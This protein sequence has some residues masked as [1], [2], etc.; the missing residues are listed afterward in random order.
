MD[1]RVKTA[2]PAEPALLA[3]WACALVE[4]RQTILPKRL[5]APGPDAKQLEQILGAAAAAPD[6]GERLPWRFVIVPAQMRSRLAEAF[7]QSLAQRDASATPQ[8]LDQAREKA[9]RA[10]LLMLAVARLNHDPL[11]TV[12][13]DERLVSAGCAIQNMLLVATALGFGSSLTSGQ[14]MQ[15]PGLRALF[16]LQPHERAL[17]FISI[18][19]PGSRKPRRPRPS[20]DQYIS[21]LGE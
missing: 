8:Q 5:G 2:G 3:E 16:S 11:D 10:P 13:D 18:G 20:P 9:H 14:A 7:A 1:V 15:S 17:C 21:V 6:H 12:T 19:T 4:A